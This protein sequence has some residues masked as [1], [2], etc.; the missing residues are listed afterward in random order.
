MIGRWWQK[1]SRKFWAVVRDSFTETFFLSIFFFLGI[2]FPA[3]VRF[4]GVPTER[5]AGLILSPFPLFS[6]LLRGFTCDLHLQKWEEIQAVLM[7][8]YRMGEKGQ[9][10]WSRWILGL[11][12]F[13]HSCAPCSA[14]WTAP[15]WDKAAAAA[16]ESEQF[17]SRAAFRLIMTPLI[18]K[19][20]KYE[21]YSQQLHCGT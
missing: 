15:E 10:N 20:F 3:L 18:C 4:Y 8:L 12:L 21:L 9:Q 19:V 17:K 16:L 11:G 2:V 1:H 5:R 7:Q 13:L 6:P 14:V